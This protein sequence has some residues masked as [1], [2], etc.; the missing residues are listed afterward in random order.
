MAQHYAKASTPTKST[1]SSSGI[2]WSD[3][4]IGAGVG[5]AIALCAGG[6]IVLSRRN[7]G[8]QLAV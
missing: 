5:F 7:R 3:S 4:G 1:T 8:Q 6:L 2:D